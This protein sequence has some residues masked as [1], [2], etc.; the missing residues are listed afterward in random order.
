MTEKKWQII[1]KFSADKL[2]ELLLENRGIKT[3]KQKAE[4]LSP[5]HPEKITT[6]EAGISNNEL[7]KAVTRV[8][9]AIKKQEQIMVYGDYDADG[10]CATAIVWEALDKLKARATPFIPD[11]FEDGYGIN[12]KSIENF[13]LQFPNIKLIITV[14]N[15]I[16]A[17]GALK[18]AKKLGIDVIITDHHTFVKKPKAYAIVHTTQTSGSGVAWFF[19]KALG[20]K[21]SI[22]LAAI[23]TIADQLPLLGVNR[24]IVKRGL[25]NLSKTTR[26]GLRKLLMVAGLLNKEIGTYEVGFM[27]APRINASGR[28]AQ[29]MDALRLLCT[30][31]PQ[32]AEKLAILLNDLN[33]ERQ[34]LVEKATKL[35]ETR[36]SQNS[37]S[38]IV[39]ASE[40][41][42][43][44]I[45][46][47]IAGRLAE[48]NNR[49]AIVLSVS[50]KI[51][52]ASARSIA[53]FNIIEAIRSQSELII[54]GGGHE[55]AAGF[56]INV[57]NITDFSQKI[58]A[59]AHPLLTQKVLDKKIKID[60]LLPFSEINQKVYNTLEILE[61]Y[62]IGNPAPVFATKGVKVLGQK[63]VGTNHLKLILGEDG[64]K[65][66]AIYF[67]KPN[68]IAADKIDICYRL[69]K[70]VWNGN[71]KLELIIKDI[72]GA[73]V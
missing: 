43:E 4:F 51:A 32:R 56:S 69:N 10:I 67:N 41:Y 61:P 27:I 46:G 64:H 33:R 1:N 52:K 29:G 14:D 5:K 15:G 57:K 20:K 9:I 23:G 42:H 48:K 19:A 26:V 60:T 8:K 6:T 18:E 40:E 25:E 28:I 36:S 66:E 73:K 35:A 50:S 13:K 2:L 71:V 59:Y 7:K 21:D 30:K 62:G 16:V 3:Q 39:I 68:K 11:R 17:Y 22:E 24:S 72:H 70:N 38:V 31:N 12:T 63:T 37:E 53:G 65:I 54:E 45:I 44:G 49:P 55:M 47:L 58:N 34:E